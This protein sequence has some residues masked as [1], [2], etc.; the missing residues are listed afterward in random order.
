MGGRGRTVGSAWILGAACSL[1]LPA[2]AGSQPVPAQ[3]RGGPTHTGVTES[4]GVERLG[5]LAWRFRTGGPVRSSPTVA[6]GVVYVGS[7]DGFL[8]ALDAP[9]GALLW[10]HDAVAPVGGA[11]LVGGS[12]VVFTDRVN[13][14]HAVDRASGEPV[15]TVETGSDLPLSWGYEGWDYL[16]PSPALSGDTVLVGSGDGHLYALSLSD[17][18]VLWRFPTEGRIRG[19]PAVRDGVVYVGSGDGFVYGVSLDAGREVWRFETAGTR[20]DAAD[21]GFD[22]TQIQA[23][24]A[25]SGGTLYVGSRDASLYAV[26]LSTRQVRWSL[27][28][29]TAWVVAS[30]AVIG[31][32]VLSGRSS[33]GTIRAV[34]RT[35]GVERWVVQTG[36]PVFASPVVVDSTVYVASM[37]GTLR[38]L[39]LGDGAQRWVYRMGAAS[40]STPALWNGRLYVGS[41]DGYLYALGRADGPPPR[42]AVYRDDGMASLSTWGRRETHL[43]AAEYFERIGYEPLDTAD[44]RA[45]LEAR[46]GDRTPSVVVFGI[47]ALPRAVADPADPASSLLRRYLDAGGKAVWLSP[48]PPLALVRR[49]DDPTRADMDRDRARRLLGVDHRAWNGDAYGV[50]VTDAGRRW[51]LET[52]WVGEPWLDPAE[53]VTPLAVDALGRISAW[54]RSYGGPVGSGFVAV[55]RAANPV[56]FGELRRVAEYGVF[57]A[58]LEGSR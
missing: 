42:L 13:R 9:T 12:A 22:R 47:D 51:G 53:S 18:R 28:E 45:F 48:Y 24:P 10:K 38:A 25:V 39:A 54:V 3:F 15:W 33:A 49:P 4:L 37:S 44:L 16:L 55:G 29:G 8:Y 7:G 23:S 20:L 56:R 31:D 14:V 40:V 58:P 6:G 17:G 27:E 36:G 1:L 35:T 32:L 50:R 34:D 26:E 21:F 52:W 46:V 11:P 2:G 30:P 41:D 5:G 57:R 43:R 19:T